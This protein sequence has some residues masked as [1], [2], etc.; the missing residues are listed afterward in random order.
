MSRHLFVGDGTAYGLTNSL[1][2]A[3]AISIEKLSDN[4]P[5]ELVAG[6]TIADSEQI[7][8]VQGTSGKNIVSPWFYGKNVISWSGKEYA[9]AAPCKQT[10]TIANTSAA[11]GTVVLK[12][13]RTGGPRPEFFSFATEIPASTA[14]TAADALVKAAY[15]AAV[16]PE[17]LNS[18]A[19][20]TAGA[21]VVFSGSKRG[22]TTQSGGSWDYE[23]V[24]FELI[25]ESYDGGTQTY[26]ASATQ[27]GDPGVGDGNAVIAFEESLH[28]VSHG[29]YDRLKMPNKPAVTASASTNY[30]MYVIAATKDGSTMS[31]IKG[32]DNLI[33]I[34]IALNAADTSDPAGARQVIESKLNGYLASAG[35]A[36]VSL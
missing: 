1:V 28:G 29:F 21:T 20:A 4:G 25:V 27:G 18:S 32:V 31:A 5:T 7:R 8:I 2:D 11:A 12:F 13:V 10:V 33:E 15:E 30:D 3:G 9:A 19:D 24:Q 22:D 17:W 35:F 6:D 26:V 34:N 23:P 36:P 14:H 16:L